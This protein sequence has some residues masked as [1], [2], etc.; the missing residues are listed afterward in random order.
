MEVKTLMLVGGSRHGFFLPIPDDLPA[1]RLSATGDATGTME[2]YRRLTLNLGRNGTI[3]VLVVDGI[4]EEEAIGLF[5]LAGGLD[6]PIRHV[7]HTMGQPAEEPA[8]AWPREPPRRELTI[9]VWNEA[10][11]QSWPI[12]DLMV[13]LGIKLAE[14][15]ESYRDSAEF[16]IEFD[17]DYDSCSVSSRISYRRPQTDEEVLSE[18]NEER[19]RRMQADAHDR[20]QYEALK[21]KFDRPT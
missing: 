8:P 15:P 9:E 18:Q 19:I 6:A 10:G 16:E 14:V 13:F 1:I 21:R 4:V 20:A 5:A 11:S 12:K 17:N 3:P 2:V 7:L